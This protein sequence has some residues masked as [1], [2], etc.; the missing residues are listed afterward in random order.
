[1]ATLHTR[2]AVIAKTMGL[3]GEQTKL[4]MVTT[5]ENRRNTCGQRDTFSSASRD[6]V[7]R[8]ALSA[9]SCSCH[10]SPQTELTRDPRLDVP[11]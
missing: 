6:L 1:M 5:V 10:V 7:R 8:G 11:Q 3:A 4:S 9:S 2:W